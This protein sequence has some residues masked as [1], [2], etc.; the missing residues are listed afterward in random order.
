MCIPRSEAEAMQMLR[1]EANGMGRAKGCGCGAMGAYHLPRTAAPV[2]VGLVDTDKSTSW[3]QQKAEE[4]LARGNAPETGTSPLD[5]VFQVAGIALMAASLTFVAWRGAMGYVVGKRLG[6]PAM[7]AIANIVGG[8]T[9]MTVLA[10]FVDDAKPNGRRRG[11]KSRRRH[12]RR[13]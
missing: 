3:V 13:A 9:G 6:Q 8:L 10:A 11:R 5:G 1:D 7:G 4:A 2:G 12:W